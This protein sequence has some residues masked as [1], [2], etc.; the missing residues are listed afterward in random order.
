M[1]DTDPSFRL[2]RVREGYPPLEDLGLIGDGATV[3]L[4]GLDGGIYWLCLPRFDSDPV[5]CGLLDRD[6]GGHFTITPDGLTEA[7]QRYE[8]DTG[9]LVTELLS[10]TGLVR[11]TDA[12]ALR[13][14]ADLTD[15]VPGGRGELVRSAVVLD[16][17]VRLWVELEPRGG[18]Q[19]WMAASGLRL[20]PS[21]RPDLQ[22]RLR[23]SRPLSGL[24]GTYDLRQ[25][26]SLDVVLSWGRSHR[27]HR[28]D[29][30]AMLAGTAAA[31]RRWM[32]HL[33][34]E[35]L[36]EPLVRRA[37]ITLKLCD[38]WVNGSLVAAPTSS[39]PAP[40]GGVRNWDHRYTWIRDAAFT[41]FA[42]RRIGDQQVPAYVD[43][44]GVSPRRSTETFAEMELELDNWRWPGTV[45]RLRTGKAL[46]RD[47]KEVAVHF[48]SV[49]HL[50][51]GHGG[52]ALPNVLR[53][54]LDPESLTLDLT[55][56]GARAHTLVPLELTARI[57]PPELPAYGRLL[58]DVLNGNAALSI[59]GD[60]AEQAWRVVAPV[61]S[62][63]SKDLVPMLEYPAGS[64]GPGAAV[65]PPP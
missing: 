20:N 31:W 59:R 46:G 2:L 49:P 7:R 34:Y 54:G 17:N 12:L 21:R 60:E 30:E 41:V 38:H 37:A 56:I 33:S 28:F 18:A 50:P 39:L 1:L 61:L 36:Q 62:A 40:V 47:R 48:R 65:G 23:S 29:A 4:V 57:D 8:P 9:V 25:G 32:T 11:L 27:H 13:S 45:F 10:P 26:D 52:E 42:L 16:G 6:R 43:E 19:A 15:D 44:E 64:Q 14:G 58:L 53:F 3:A 63:W 35:G 24:H 55:G 22:L 51:F 5:F